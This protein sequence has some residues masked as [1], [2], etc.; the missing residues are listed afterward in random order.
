MFD[1]GLQEK[2]SPRN[3]RRKREGKG[4]MR[5]KLVSQAGRLARSAGVWL[6]SALLCCSGAWS[7]AP[8]IPWA[9]AYT[10]RTWTYDTG[11]K[12]TAAFDY[13]KDGT[14]HVLAGGNDRQA[15]AMNR[16]IAQ[17]QAWI[18]NELKKPRG[19]INDVSFIEWQDRR[20][21]FRV[22]AS[23]FSKGNLTESPVVCVQYLLLDPAGRTVKRLCDPVALYPTVGKHNHELMG[24]MAAKQFPG[25]Q[26]EDIVRVDRLGLRAVLLLLHDNRKEWLLL[27]AV[28]KQDYERLRTLGLPADWWDPK[29]PPGLWRHGLDKKEGK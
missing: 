20:P 8:E 16:L 9:K 13:Y 19:L 26:E 25:F 5:G 14:V 10:P 28:S 6:A 7:A 24:T 23:F 18:L 11:T 27:D 17:D 1:D 21:V 22:N 4:A 29:Y 2:T 15:I 3:L 12:V